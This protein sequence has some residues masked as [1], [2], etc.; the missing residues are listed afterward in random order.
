MR[1]C[2]VFN[3]GVHCPLGTGCQRIDFSSL[4]ESD[5]ESDDEERME[6]VTSHVPPLPDGVYTSILGLRGSF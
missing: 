3:H 6:N 2:I 5:G 4:T 1:L